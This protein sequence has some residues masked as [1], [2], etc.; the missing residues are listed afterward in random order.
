[1]HLSSFEDL[2]CLIFGY[3][4]K[5]YTKLFMEENMSIIFDGIEFSEPVK[6]TEWISPYRPGIFVVFISVEGE[7]KLNL[8]PVY[9]GEAENIS[10]SEFFIHHGEFKNWLQ[11]AKSY[12]NIFIAS[13][14]MH[15]SSQNHRYKLVQK[16]SH[17]NI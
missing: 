6:L 9:F 1:M 16:L 13:Y 2:Y 12:E 3:L 10:D 4:N 14:L 7:T 5:I 8:K 11:F 17:Q 15:S